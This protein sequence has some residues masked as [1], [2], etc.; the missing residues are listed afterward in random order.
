M[1]NKVKIT[2][3]RSFIGRP[4]DQRVTAKTLGLRKMHS[5]VIHE[6]TPAIRGMIR[7]I[8]HLVKVEEVTA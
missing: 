4:E 3:V 2:L 7:K 8:N 6:D 5:S 1:T